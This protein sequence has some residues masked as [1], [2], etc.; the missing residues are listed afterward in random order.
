MYFRSWIFL[1]FEI[2]LQSQSR[3]GFTVSQN[4]VI[5][6]SRHIRLMASHGYHTYVTYI[7]WMH[8]DVADFA[9]SNAS[10]AH[11]RQA[12]T[13]ARWLRHSCWSGPA[14]LP[15]ARWG[16]RGRPLVRAVGERPMSTIL[17]YRPLSEPSRQITKLHLAR[18]SFSLPFSPVNQRFISKFGKAIFA[19]VKPTR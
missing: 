3:I 6:L 10:R 11:Q 2:V 5:S 4:I 9:Q 13:F 1:F 19:E 7:A 16:R 15:R 12:S 8:M 18:H 17:P 14:E